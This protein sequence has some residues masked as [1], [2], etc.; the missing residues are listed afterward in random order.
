MI[1]LSDTLTYLCQITGKPII[2]LYNDIEQ[3]NYYYLVDTFKPA[4]AGNHMY[5]NDLQGRNLE[6]MLNS[7]QGYSHGNNANSDQAI[8]T[9]IEELPVIKLTFHGF[10]WIKFNA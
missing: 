4:D 3:K 10:R 6:G 5:D 9:K 7:V 1:L 8:L 2:Y